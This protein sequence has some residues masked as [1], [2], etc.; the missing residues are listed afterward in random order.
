MSGRKGPDVSAENDIHLEGVSFAYPS[1]RDVQV[2]D[3]VS[4]TFEQRKTTAIVGPSGSGKSTVVGLLERWYGLDDYEVPKQLKPR[5]T[6]VEKAAKDIKQPDGTPTP[7]G[8]PVPVDTRVK[9]E[10]AVETGQGPSSPIT[11]M[12][13]EETIREL[14][15]IQKTIK[16][17]SLNPVEREF[18]SQRYSSNPLENGFS[19]RKDMGK[20]YVI[21][22]VSATA[23]SVQ[24]E[25]EITEE[26]IISIPYDQTDEDKAP[27]S[28]RPPIEGR[29]VVGDVDL[30]TIDAKWWRAQ[31]GLVQQE[32]FLFNATIY[33]NIAFGLVGTPYEH[34]SEEEKEQ[35][36]TDACRLAFADEFI[37]RLP[38]G[39]K[40]TVGESGIKLS[41]GQRQRIAIARAVVKRPS[42]LIL[43]EATSAIDVRTEKIVQAALDR[44]SEGRTTIVIAHR[45]ST[46]KKADKIVVM[47]KGQVMEEGTHQELLK[48]DEGIYSGLVRAQNI[49]MGAE[50][51]QGDEEDSEEEQLQLIK[52]KS[53]T[54]T[55]EP[56][57]SDG[58][59]TKDGLLAGYKKVGFMRSFGQILYEQRR[60]WPQ[61]CVTLLTCAAA[62]AVF[63]V[64]S[65]IFAQLINAFTVI[66][67]RVI[68][69]RTNYWALIMFY[70]ACAMLVVYFVLAWTTHW[71]GIN[72]T[73]KYRQEYLEN[74]LRKR[75]AFFD[76]EGNSP[77]SISSRV[78]SDP[79]QIEMVLG[80]QM[81]MAYVSVFNLLGSLIIAFYYGWKLSLV[82][83]CVILPI[84]LGAGFIRVRLELK[85][86]DM[87]AKVFAESSQFAVEAVS[88]FRTVTSLILEDT[89]EKRYDELMS[90]HVKTAT[91]KSLTWT[92]A[93]AFSNSADMLCQAFMFWYGG[94]LLRD[95]EYDIVQFFVIFQS[96]VQGGM[97]AGIWFSFAPNI[98]NATAGLNRILSSRYSS[99]ELEHEHKESP[100]SEKNPD[101][102]FDDVHFSYR[103]RNLTVLTGLNLDIKPGQFV[104]LVGATGCGKSTT[105]SLLERFYDTSKGAVLYGSQDVK[106][107]NVPAYRANIS[108]VAQES[109]LYEGTIRENVCLSVEETDATQARMYEAC[110]SAQIHDFITSLPEGYST[111][112]GPKGV[113][114]SGGQRQRLALARALMRDP[115]VL[116]LDEA[117]SSL[118][119]ESEK[120]VQ[121]AIDKAAAKGTRT[122]IAVA[123]RLATIQKADVIFVLGSG[124]VLER[125]SHQELLKARGVYYSMVCLNLFVSLNGDANIGPQC[126]AQALDR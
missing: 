28:D 43:D 96:I 106:N 2:L 29:I 24:N 15:R 10:L 81:A 40:T 4:I 102:E 64:Q 37:T 61:Y 91:V 32:P 107:I 19:F 123:H 105:I 76:A 33:T 79:E 116:L 5:S 35:M 48:N 89:I 82:G 103:S 51:H 108:L 122:I 38:E 31:I 80:A 34:L 118:D 71:I 72:V 3:K 11:K 62:G 100:P 92:L 52:T 69:D 57:E 85:F 30:S 46:I 6:S 26:K 1:R 27:T 23:S 7:V 49:A 21:P 22:E 47:R 14:A 41:G 44:A 114:L 86:E 111:Y 16:R 99:P 59:M 117:T 9:E 88:A 18:N 104:A 39:Y 42:I 98:A 20:A 70:V 54:G 78:A 74:V 58:I 55:G 93:F 63:P 73:R 95:R 65:Y 112:L 87:N 12:P 126:Q 115:H 120:L 109:T 84:V 75:I 94:T 67:P 125:G 101:I 17:N 36:V 97:A 124:K 68:S 77:G 25:K 50:D 8:M 121:E 113:Q 56:V 13:S 60:L 119:S 110:R 66:D 53:L 83:T 45:L 90:Q